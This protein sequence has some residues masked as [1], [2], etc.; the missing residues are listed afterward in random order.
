[1]KLLHVSFGHMVMRDLYD[2]HKLFNIAADLEIN[3]YI[4]D[5]LSS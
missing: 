4:D 2:N 3:Q 1:M 5:G